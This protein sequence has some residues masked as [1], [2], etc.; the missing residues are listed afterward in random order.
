MEKQYCQSPGI[1]ALEGCYLPADYTLLL[2]GCSLQCLRVSL[3]LGVSGKASFDGWQLRHQ[4]SPRRPRVGLN[5]AVGKQGR[6]DGEGLGF[7]PCL[8]SVAF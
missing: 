5:A 4:G 8:L 6:T 3:D 2:P 7:P 1:R